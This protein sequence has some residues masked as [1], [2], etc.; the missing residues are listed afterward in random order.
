L[1]EGATRIK[2]LFQSST[3]GSPPI[4]KDLPVEKS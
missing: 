2:S 1:M 4:Q 3:K